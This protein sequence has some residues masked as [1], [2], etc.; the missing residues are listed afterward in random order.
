MKNY[1][2]ICR[3]SISNLIEILTLERLS[4]ASILLRLKI[5]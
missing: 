4:K 5:N 3:Q 2:F 1:L